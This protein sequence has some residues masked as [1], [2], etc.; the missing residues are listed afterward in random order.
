MEKTEWRLCF[1][2]AV[3]RGI[4]RALAMDNVE[5]NTCRFCREKI[6]ADAIKCRYCGEFLESQ[7]VIAFSTYIE[8]G[9]VTGSNETPPPQKFRCK[10]QEV[11]QCAILLSG[12]PAKR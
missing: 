9:R 12:R 11:C 6:R 8:E 4:L 2:S 10:K 7:P 1:T 3:G 5:F